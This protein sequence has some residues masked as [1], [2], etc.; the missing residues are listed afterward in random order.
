MHEK[1]LIQQQATATAAA[2]RAANR[3][4]PTKKANAALRGRSEAMQYSSTT[5]TAERYVI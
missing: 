3:S 5:A 1:R 4:A 2:N